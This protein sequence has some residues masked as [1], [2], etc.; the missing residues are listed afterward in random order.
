M[1]GANA[2]KSIA[3][4]GMLVGGSIGCDGDAAGVNAFNGG[5]ALVGGNS[6]VIC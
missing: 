6:T 3:G 1:I 5:P 4:G 2:D